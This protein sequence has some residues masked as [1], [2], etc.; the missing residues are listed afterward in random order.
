M[1]E[2]PIE[3]NPDNYEWGDAVEDPDFQEWGETKI[4]GTMDNPWLIPEEDKKQNLETK[5]EL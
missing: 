4:E 2:I 5:K 1:S 3:D